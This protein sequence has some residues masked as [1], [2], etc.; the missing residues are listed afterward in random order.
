M[1]D[2]LDPQNEELLRDF[3]S[4]AESQVEALE[5]NILVLE[6]DP[7]NHDS[8]D[9]LFRAAHTLKGAAATV[10]MMELSEFTHLLEDVLD[11]VRSG[12]VGVDNEK[13]DTLLQ[14][15][16]LIKAMLQARQDG[17]V[18]SGDTE[19][20]E[21]KLRSLLVSEE[22][23]EQHAPS[24]EQE[25]SKSTATPSDAQGAE[26]SAP[27]PERAPAV[28][29]PSSGQGGVSVSEELLKEFREIADS[30]SV[31][32][33]VR[34]EFDESNPM[35]TVGGIQVFAALKRIGEVLHTD[36]E[37]EE[38]Y[39]DKFFPIVDY[40]VAA[41][42]DV[43]RIRD[44]TSISD[45]TRSVAVERVV[46]P[47]EAAQDAG[48]TSE[49]AARTEHGARA[50]AEVEDRKDPETHRGGGE[51]ELEAGS[52]SVEFTTS[53][54]DQTPT[55]PG[56]AAESA[57]KSEESEAAESTSPEAAVRKSKQSVTGSVL[58]VD[59]KRIDDLLNLVSETVINKAAFNQISSAFA[60][61]LSEF[62]N[63]DQRHR[64]LLR[65][66]FDAVPRMVDKIQNG[67]S[68]RKVKQELSSRFGELFDLFEDVQRDFKH[69]VNKFRGNSQNLGRITSEL[70]EGVMRIRMVPIAHIFSRFPRLVR[71]LSRSLNK[72]IS[73]EIEGEDTELDKS[74][75]EDL[76]DPLIH[77]VRNS[78]DHGIEPPNERIEAGKERTGSVKMRAG[79]EGNLIVIEVTDDGR[80][81]D[82]DAIRTKAVERGVIHPNK[83]LT[84]VEAFNLIFDPGFS[85]AKEI[86]NV[87][88]RGVGLDVVKR[89]I[90]RL[91]GTVSVWS[92]L[93]LGT[94]FTIK[95]PL[96]LA[97]IQG[98]LV[99]VGSEMYAIP[100]TSVIESHRIRPNEIKLIDNYEVINV[101]E[102]V[103]SLLR[104][105]RLFNIE[106]SND[107][108]YYYVVIVGSGDKKVGLIV[109]SL[110][111]EEDVVIKPLRDHYTNAPGIAGANI[112]G[113][114]T[115]SLII[116]VSQLLELGLVREREARRNREATIGA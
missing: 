14:A 26:R 93:G 22:K 47:G 32:F 70:Q 108:E 109:D 72:E 99:R 97:I 50:A 12:K 112:T 56:P 8:V 94:R 13:T 34:V 37:F 46:A 86:T 82:V 42:D 4:E 17:D 115:V 61:N 74:V 80:G 101:R 31:L 52:S 48:R 96:T 111:G 71:D 75:I 3:F 41:E 57:E 65:E 49:A 35:N 87:S 51:M 11:E 66:L 27:E 79:N 69:S 63:A 53:G 24:G 84:D 85:T 76:L 33:R 18:Y 23:A 106:T 59:S 103:I 89:Q 105:S 15:I 114:G 2:Y 62:E 38:L 9:E 95:I 113:D 1:G 60:E 19:A 92:E 25:T 44:V 100:I 78:I 90:E 45:V 5:S 30:D 67:E 116:D 107:R 102:D 81:I 58:R 88:G 16:D 20:V 21:A 28:Q 43:D 7:K 77:C 39:D 40:F 68:S 55:E 36:P 98:L 64:E 110:I 6:N 73:L 54:G 104:L 29:A 83:Q 10:Q 91:N